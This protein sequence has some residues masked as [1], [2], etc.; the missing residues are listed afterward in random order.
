[1]RSDAEAIIDLEYCY[2][3]I[4]FKIMD[5]EVNASL[6][7]VPKCAALA[8][9]SSGAKLSSACEHELAQTDGFK[10]PLRGNIAVLR[11]HYDKFDRS[12]GTEAISKYRDFP[13]V[14][15]I[16]IGPASRIACLLKAP[17]K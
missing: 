12:H 8:E 3:I 5:E 4:I 7:R 13:A 2:Y 14:R 17:A 16:R 10:V 15:S 1:M 9:T 6:P 11:S